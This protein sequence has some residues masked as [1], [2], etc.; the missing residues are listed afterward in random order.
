MLA[1]LEK[2]Q[3][4]RSKGVSF[5]DVADQL[6]G[7]SSSDCIAAYRMFITYSLEDM[8]PGQ[9]L[10][11]SFGDEIL[12][13]IKLSKFENGQIDSEAIIRY[14]GNYQRLSMVGQASKSEAEKSESPRESN[15]SS[16]LSQSNVKWTPQNHAS[17]LTALELMGRWN[18]RTDWD[19]VAAYV[20]GQTKL[21][22]KF[23]YH[24]QLVKRNKHMTHS[25]ASQEDVN[26]C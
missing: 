1:E 3:D 21:S 5:I 22:C 7:K 20:G 10:A 13:V 11:N 4:L 23:R 2:L 24:S 15:G 8:D 12:N 18:R 6:P 9:T 19:A 16:Y 17:L 25:Q 26:S 14:L